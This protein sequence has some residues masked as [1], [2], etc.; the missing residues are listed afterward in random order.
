[1]TGSVGGAGDGPPES[2][3]V[4]GLSRELD[5]LRRKVNELAALPAQLTDLAQTVTE[6]TERVAKLTATRDD[7]GKR[8][9][10]VQPSSVPGWLTL[11]EDAPAAAAAAILTDLAGWLRA[12]YLRF[13]DAASVFP[14]CWAWHPEVVEELLWLRT[15]HAAAYTGSR[16]SVA[17][18]ADWHDRAR[19]GVVQ[20]IRATAGMCSVELHEPDRPQN[21]PAPDVPFTAAIDAI[22]AWWTSN[23][24]AIGP[25]PVLP[26][27]RRRKWS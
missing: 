4:L 22:A 9:D 12:V 1:M 8:T 21:Q 15:A 5:A 24:T 11:P 26:P 2:A 25:E 16:A 7:A 10:A 23:R 19:P 20:R 17:A 13:R 27:G 6:L 3:V 14:E 18:V